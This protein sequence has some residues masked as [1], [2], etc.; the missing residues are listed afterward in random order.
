VVGL[1]VDLGFLWGVLSL[2]GGGAL[3]AAALAHRADLAGADALVLPL[4]GEDRPGF[5]LEDASRVRA[6]LRKPLSIAVRGTRLL[7][8]AVALGPAEI[9]FLSDSG[10]PVKL[11]LETA[12]TGPLSEATARVRKAGL[13][14][15]I[16][17]APL[18][19]EV[20]AAQDA[21]AGAVELHAGEFA[22][23][24]TDDHALDAFRRLARAAR[25]ASD[26]GM[27]V[28]T[29][30]GAPVPARVS[31]LAEV[32]EVE[33]VRAGAA[34]LA[35]CFYE[36]VGPAVAALRTEVERGSRRGERIREEEEEEE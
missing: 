15:V 3:D 9:L 25:S 26:V 36:G 17:V 20:L 2:E 30:G 16:S 33:Q 7:K 19:A 8:E 21:G 5:T 32:P 29:G 6:I 13:L 4:G 18:E 22:D 11:E 34:L 1:A 23:A 14:P 12:G 10:G 27:R 24:R 28:R 31:R 35:G